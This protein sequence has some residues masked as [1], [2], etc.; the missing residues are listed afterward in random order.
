ML[1]P[2]AYIVDAVR[3]PIGRHH[4]AL[5]GAHPADLV[6][7]VVTALLGRQG[8]D[9]HEVDDVVFGVCDPI[10]PHAADVARTGWLAAGLDE[11]VPGVVID[12]QC[13]SSQQAF[14]FAAQAVM[15]GTQDVVVA[16]GVQNMSM[17]PIGSALAAAAPFGHPDPYTGSSGWG[18]RYGVAEVSQFTAVETVCEQQGIYRTEMEEYA[19]LSQ[20][21]AVAA[22]DS[23]RFDREIVPYGGFA[24]DETPRRNSSL[25]R[26]QGMEPL[27]PGGRLTPALCSQICDAAAALLVMSEQAVERAG[28]TPL[29]RVAHLDVRA[30][31]PLL[32]V[33]GA[34][35]A[36]E[37]ALARSGLSLD[38]IDLVEINEAFAA[39]PLMWLK[40]F[41]VGVDRVNV[42]GSGLSL[43]HP[44]GA[45]GARVLT[46]LVHELHAR[47]A[48]RG[49]QITCA[50]GG[51]ANVTVVERV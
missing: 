44:I 41:P 2:H 17:V 42:V 6:G 29:A 18:D 27:R 30:A 38:D 1:R 20:Q 8:L 33:T 35:V 13:A 5:A 21:R 34:L 45:T 40:H 11:S 48:D 50:G 7:H 14:H 49:M 15:S 3:T 43:G 47:G 4:G 10:G 16:G 31:D 9:P 19:H 25:E 51:Q 37:R 28:V 26:M 22:S 12:R 39:V 36:T 46:T 23:G 24:V 32:I